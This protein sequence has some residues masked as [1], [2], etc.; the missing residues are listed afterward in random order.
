MTQKPA[1]TV[2]H[3]TICY[4]DEATVS[5]QGGRYWY[6]V[7]TNQLSQKINI[8]P[9]HTTLYVVYSSEYPVHVKGYI[10]A[11]YSI[12]TAWVIVHRDA[13]TPISGDT[14]VC[15]GEHTYSV[16]D[17]LEVNWWDGN[18]E[19]PRTV[20]INSDTTLSYTGLSKNGCDMRDTQFVKVIANSEGDIQGESSFCFGDTVVLSVEASGANIEWFNGDTS[21]EIRFVANA[22]FTAYCQ[23]SV[24]SG[25]D[26]S[27]RL[28]H[29]IEVKECISVF[30][31]S[32]FKPDG[33][34]PTYGPVGAIDPLKKYEF[35]I[36]SCTGERIFE[37]TDLNVRW[38]GK[39]KGKDAPAGVYIYQY[40]ETVEHFT[41]EKRGTV[42][43]VK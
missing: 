14:I 12:D 20:V 35:S 21:T 32:G 30:F 24:G 29:P 18:T 23:F 39:I 11:C 41:F 42:T 1:T 28:E 36:Y 16:K 8:R 2:K 34:T 33:V 43:L 26:C 38:D 3:D 31:P 40:R 7:D 27:K 6:W 17:A 25:D 4:G 37:T 13:S 5:V 15:S 22:S 9:F 19:N 10:N